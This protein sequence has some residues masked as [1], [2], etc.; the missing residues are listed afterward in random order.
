MAY[1]LLVVD[2][3]KPV[4]DTLGD[5]FRDLGYTVKTAANG[6]EAMEIIAD[7]R[8]DVI[9]SDIVMP[10]MNGLD[11]LRRVRHEYPMVRVI[12]TTG[13]VA[14]E[15]ILAAMRHG[16]ETCIFKPWPNLEELDTAVKHAVT[17]LTT[18][19]KKLHQL[20]QMRPDGGDAPDVL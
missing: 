1:H 4:R 8:V 10:Q 3:E 9:I 6:A 19:K 15:N 5:H 7:Q 17:G 14:Q 2:D 12:M 16:A 20:H 18:W 13:Y 11:I